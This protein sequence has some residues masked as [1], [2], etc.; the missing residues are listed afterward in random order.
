MYRRGRSERIP[1]LMNARL[2]VALVNGE[3]LWQELYLGGCHY[4]YV[5]HLDA[6]LVETDHVPDLD[7]L[8]PSDN[9]RDQARDFWSH[10]P[11]R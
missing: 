1:V 4:P 7:E 2:V 10:S 11:R 9:A 3:T 6:I 8:G 5:S